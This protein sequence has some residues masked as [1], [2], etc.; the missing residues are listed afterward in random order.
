MSCGAAV[1]IVID[2]ILMNTPV[3]KS[4]TNHKWERIWDDVW[5][6]GAAGRTI[7][8]LR[9]RYSAMLLHVIK[10]YLKSQAHVLELGSGTGTLLLSLAEDI[11]E[12]VGLDISN[13]AIAIA[14][15]NLQKKLVKNISFIKADCRHVPYQGRF[16]VV[17]SAGLIEH[18]FAQ[19]IEIVRQHLKAAKP[20]GT[21]V[22]S[23]PYAYSLH[24]LHYMLTRPRLSR[25]LWPWSRERNFQLFYSRQR[26]RRLALNVS[27]SHRI[28]LLPPWPVGL[29]LG[30]IVLVINKKEN[31]QV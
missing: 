21:V 19:D 10:P 30:I 6:T 7:S 24:S 20:G 3:V 17:Y 23:V 31:I 15:K 29:L 2:S 9:Q 16:D 26:L 5:R 14:N 27:H 11:T 13:E 28:F 1:V 4:A 22:I 18:F 25:W 8:W 12:G